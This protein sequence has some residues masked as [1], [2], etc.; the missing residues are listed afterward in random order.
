[1]ELKERETKS[2]EIGLK[3]TA[4]GDAYLA[5]W[6]ISR[7]LMQLPAVQRQQHLGSP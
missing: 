7:A 2:R 4:L 3:L 1:M 5:T 6:G